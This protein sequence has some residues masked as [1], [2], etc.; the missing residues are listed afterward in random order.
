MACIVLAEAKRE[1]DHPSSGRHWCVPTADLVAL[2]TP[3]MNPTRLPVHEGVVAR[4]K[5]G[6][7]RLAGPGFCPHCVAQ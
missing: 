7:L 5:K 1:W 2:G 3:S 6:T 4:G